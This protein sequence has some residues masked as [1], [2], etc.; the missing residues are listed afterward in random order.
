MEQQISI[1]TVRA[2]TKKLI[3]TLRTVK[4]AIGKMSA[5]T[6]A[7]SAEITVTDGKITFAVPGAVFPLECISQG[8]CKASVPFLHVVQ[9]IKDSRV[10]ETQILITEESLT[11]N[12]VSISVKTTFF[13]DDSI[14]RTIDLPINYTEADLIRL[15]NKGYTYEEL[16]FNNLH[17]KIDDAYYNLD[18]N[19]FKAYKLL[20]QYGIDFSAL[21]E[22]VHDKLFAKESNTIN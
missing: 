10:K 17:S 1:V 13:E 5:K 7:V 3:Q 6:K 19:I 4:A 15:N 2:N 11:I 9:I 8:V 20:S 22:M 16:E 18:D 14:L 21:K 12:N